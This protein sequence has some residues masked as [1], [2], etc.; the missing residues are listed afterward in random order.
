MQAFNID[1][2]IDESGR[3]LSHIAIENKHV[4]VL[5]VLLKEFNANPNVMDGKNMTTLMHCVSGTGCSLSMMKLLAKNGFDFAK[6]INECC[7][8]DGNTLFHKLCA[9]HFKHNTDSIACL[10]YLFNVCKKIENC[11]INVLAKNS[12]IM[13]GLHIAIWNS[14]IDMV[15]YL[16]ENVYFP[17]NNKQYKDGVEFLNMIPYGKIPLVHFTLLAS[18]N[19]AVYNS[20]WLFE[21]FK[22]LS[23][24]GMTMKFPK[25]L[26]HMVTAPAIRHAVSKQL[27]EIIEFILNENL[28]PVTTFDELI[29]LMYTTDNMNVN[30]NSEILKSLYNYGLNYYLIVENDYDQQ[31]TIISIAASINL[32][33]FKATLS[34]ILQIPKHQLH[35]CNNDNMTCATVEILRSVAQ[36]LDTKKDVKSF[37]EALITNDNDERRLSQ[38]DTAMSKFEKVALTCVNNHEMKNINN[39][40]NNYKQMCSVC[41][42]NSDGTQLLNG[43]QCDECKSFICDD[44][45]ITKQIST[46]LDMIG[47]E[48]VD[49]YFSSNEEYELSILNQILQYKSNKKLLAKV[50]L[51]IHKYTV[52][53]I[54]FLL[55][56]FLF[57][58]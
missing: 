52:L 7:N 6:L 58:V 30:I 3:T 39:K 8:K 13:C 23:S 47:D 1:K 46:K 51:S 56:F 43:I 9:I 11:S 37:I 21:I 44:C 16:L 27:T 55:L 10:K 15:R 28:C 17:D 36:R 19:I 5:E 45:V 57:F 18:Q 33:T 35:A 25:M 31:W 49:L 34:M 12:E 29:N 22:L 26:K 48:T 24:Y 14:N 38:P 50:K 41:R 2:E 42:D 20:E 40:I 4:K 32:T 53:L 54:L